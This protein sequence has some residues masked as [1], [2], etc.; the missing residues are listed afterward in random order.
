MDLITY[1]IFGGIEG[2]EWLISGSPDIVEHLSTHK[3]ME[4]KYVIWS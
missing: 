2:N 4:T 3:L 1:S